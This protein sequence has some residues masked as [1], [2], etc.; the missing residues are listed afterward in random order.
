MSWYVLLTLLGIVFSLPFFWMLSSS[1]K[2]EAD[3][4]L[5]PPK[6]IPDP[7]L[8]ENYPKALELMNFPRLLFNTLFLVAVGT[9]GDDA[10]EHVGG[11][12]LHP[13]PLQGPRRGLR[14]AAVHDDAARAR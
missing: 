13:L 8:W 10:V 14:R 6:W 7:V 9:F 2:I 5:Y 12:R 11:V 3:I 4:W 1:L